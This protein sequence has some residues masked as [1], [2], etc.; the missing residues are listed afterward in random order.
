MRTLLTGGNG[1]IGTACV[2]ALQARGIEVLAPSSREL[3][4]LDE[5]AVAA[6]LLDARPTHLVHAAWRPVHGDV[7]ASAD[8]EIWKEVSLALLRRFHEAGGLKAVCL[9]SCSEYGCERV[10]HRLQAER[11][12]PY[13]QPSEQ[14]WLFRTTRQEPGCAMRGCGFLYFHAR[15]STKA[16]DR[17]RWK[18]TADT[19]KGNSPSDEKISIR[20]LARRWCS[21]SSLNSRA[22]RTSPQACSGRA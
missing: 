20:P 14:T 1:F 8:N 18:S 17:F 19:A 7:L 5:R 9:G 2:D 10:P 13:G 3:N 6:F 15:T 21:P 22:Q 11:S 16:S 4:L 12:N